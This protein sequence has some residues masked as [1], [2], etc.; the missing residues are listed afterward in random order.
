M[1]SATVVTPLGRD[2]LKDERE[3]ELSGMEGTGS[4]P[5]ANTKNRWRPR[6]VGDSIR[7]GHG[8]VFPFLGRVGGTKLGGSKC[9]RTLTRNQVARAVQGKRRSNSEI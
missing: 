2:P 8:D 1:T 7:R 9:W 3:G 5:G 4:S 6:C